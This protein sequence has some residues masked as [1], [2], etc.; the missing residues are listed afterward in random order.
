MFWQPKLD[1]VKGY[2]QWLPRGGDGY[3][4]DLDGAERITRF[5]QG[6]SPRPYPPLIGCVSGFMPQQD[7]TFFNSH[8]GKT[9]SGP[10]VTTVPVNLQWQMVFPALA[11]TG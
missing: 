1:K 10:N 8:I 2:N 6:V 4:L 3:P 7:I 5:R 11:K 9:P